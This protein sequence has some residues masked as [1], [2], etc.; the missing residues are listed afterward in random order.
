MASQKKHKEK[1]R[2]KRDKLMMEE[3]SRAP[4]P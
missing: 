1:D 4:P 3:F 2:L